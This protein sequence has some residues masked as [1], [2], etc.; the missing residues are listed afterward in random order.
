MREPAKYPSEVWDGLSDNTQRTNR[1]DDAPPDSRDWDRLVAE[2][3]ATQTTLS[4]L[5]LAATEIY[6]PALVSG[7]NAM[8]YAGVWNNTTDYIKGHV[9]WYGTEQRSYVCLADDASGNAPDAPES[10]GIWDYLSD[11]SS[12]TDLPALASASGSSLNLYVLDSANGAWSDLET[13]VLG[14]S[15]GGA[16]NTYET[17]Y[18]DSLQIFRHGLPVRL[19]QI[20]NTYGTGATANGNVEGTTV[21]STN[22]FDG[23]GFAVVEDG[24]GNRTNPVIMY[25]KAQVYEAKVPDTGCTAWSVIV[26]A[27]NAF[28]T[29]ITVTQYGGDYEAG[30]VNT[31]NKTFT[32]QQGTPVDETIIRLTDS[33]ANIEEATAYGLVYNGTTDGECDIDELISVQVDGTMEFTAYQLAWLADSAE[34]DVA[35]NLL[36]VGDSY[37]AGTT[38][39]LSPVVAGSYCVPVGDVISPTKIKLN[40]GLPAPT[41]G[42][43]VPLASTASGDPGNLYLL[44]TTNTPAEWTSFAQ[45]GHVEYRLVADGAST[46]NHGDPLR[47]VWS[48]PALGTGTGNSG[49]IVAETTINTNLLNDILFTVV[50]DPTPYSNVTNPPTTFFDGASSYE[51][52]VHD[53]NTTTLNAILTSWMTAN[54][55]LSVTL[56]AGNYDP[57]SMSPADIELSIVGGA[58][59]MVYVERATL[60]GTVAEATVYGLA[61]DWNSSGSFGPGQTVGIQTEGLLSINSDQTVNT[62][63]VASLSSSNTLIA[64]TPYYLGDPVSIVNGNVTEEWI[65]PIGV[66]ASETT[67]KIRITNPI[68]FSM[69]A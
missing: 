38:F 32:I 40:I 51:C 23:V 49:N 3:I 36:I 35:T 59:D 1:N 24:A 21:L 11:I 44:C 15:G 41:A 28:Q 67:L 47:L 50:E 20:Q 66:A 55:L 63:H 26:D 62:I 9:V 33:T 31:E 61:V 29:D 52:Y 16:G 25:T 57:T 8:S 13:A 5:G 58:T 18:G 56:L 14:I 22:T 27:W 48:Q 42:T 69:P 2:T 12:A 64:G 37:Y 4:N 39:P 60:G 30:T 6:M 53:T 10:V 45:V 65:V 34:L 7:N 46:I 68:K 43:D 17:Y 54:N 19:C